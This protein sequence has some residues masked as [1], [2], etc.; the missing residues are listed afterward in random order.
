M[1]A[2]TRNNL[3]VIKTL[4]EH[5]ANPLLRNKDGWNCFHIASREGH[6]EVLQYLLEVSPS[7]WDTQGTT[8]RTPLHTAGTAR[9]EPG[10]LRAVHCG[11]GGVLPARGGG[12]IQTQGVLHPSWH[13]PLSLGPLDQ[14]ILSSLPWNMDV[15][16]L[17]AV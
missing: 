9:L 12:K 7:C 16:F 2:C 6:P 15:I 11:K 14:G 5:G 4:V 10:S 13:L 17:P 3:A 1:M 8:G